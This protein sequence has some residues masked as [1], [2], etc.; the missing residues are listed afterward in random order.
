MCNFDIMN[1]LKYKR[2]ISETR[3]VSICHFL[4]VA[5]GS[6]ET[7]THV[8]LMPESHKILSWSLWV[9]TAFTIVIYSSSYLGMH[10]LLSLLVLVF[11]LPPH[12]IELFMT[13]MKM[14]KR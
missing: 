14:H 5:M 3:C 12:H 1:L 10:K 9:C 6:L 7:S 13:T 11:P 4:G 8:I 2:F